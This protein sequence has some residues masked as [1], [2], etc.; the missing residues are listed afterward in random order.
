MNHDTLVAFAL[1]LH[2][3]NL[4]SMVPQTFRLDVATERAEFEQSYRGQSVVLLS[5]MVL[6]SVVTEG[7][8]WICK[9]TGANQ[10]HTLIFYRLLVILFLLLSRERESSSFRA[11][12][13]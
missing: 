4:D 5:T 8:Q 9:P 7:E 12:S 13:R 2:R 10:V 6:V 11:F 3:L 1:C